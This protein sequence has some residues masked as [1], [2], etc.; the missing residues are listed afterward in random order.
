MDIKIIAL[1]L[2]CDINAQRWDKISD[3]FASDAS[4]YWHNTNE[5]FTVSEFVKA[6][7][8]YP[9]NWAIIPEKAL[10]DGNTAITVVKVTLKDADVSFH[11]TSFFQFAG[12][13]IISLD[14]YWGD[15]GP[16]PQ[17]RQDSGLG[18]PIVDHKYIDNNN[19]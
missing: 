10:R 16:A 2:W 3:Y 1:S 6:N 8:E 5:Q 7:S 9:G 14:E 19:F 11:A 18:K 4:I 17:W 15:D 12:D 13:K